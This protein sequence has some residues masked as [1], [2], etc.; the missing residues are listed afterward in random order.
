MCSIKSL[1]LGVIL[2]SIN[3]T[4]V[5]ETSIANQYPTYQNGFLVIPRIDTLDKANEYQDVIL[6]LDVEQSQFQL[7]SLQITET[8]PRPYVDTVELVMTDS[9]PIQVFLKV[10]GFFT[11]DCGK[12]GQV[13]QRLNG[14]RFEIIILGVTYP[15]PMDYTC[16][17]SIVSFEKVIPLPV[18]DLVAGI[19]EYSVSDVLVFKTN[20]SGSERKDFTGSFELT[21]DNKL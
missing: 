18:Y 4:A 21:R 15:Q 11:D 8:F 7:Q 2:A 3:V 9:F 1:F 5:A 16:G 20:G 13:S 19:Y 17:A 14:N 10:N 6:K 12:L